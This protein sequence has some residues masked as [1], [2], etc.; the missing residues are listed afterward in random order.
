MEN[1]VIILAIVAEFSKFITW[2]LTILNLLVF[3]GAIW[4]LF[5][6]GYKAYN[7]DGQA[8]KSL[9]TIV[10][11]LVIWIAGTSVLKTYITGNATAPQSIDSILK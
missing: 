6:Y 7:G 1:Y 2:G 11:V 9:I 5:N 8:S 4:A 10:I 3:G